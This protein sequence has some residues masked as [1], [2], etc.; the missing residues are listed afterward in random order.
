MPGQMLEGPAVVEQFD[1]TVVITPS[2]SSES[3][4][5]GNMILTSK[6]GT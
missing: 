2:F 5:Y 3:D 1:S 6:D 4:I